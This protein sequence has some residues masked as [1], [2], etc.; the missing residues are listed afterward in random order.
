M[1]AQLED[2]T[3]VW[4]TPGDQR[5]T[6]PHLAIDVNGRPVRQ[7]MGFERD[8]EARAFQEALDDAKARLSGTGRASRPSPH[9]TDG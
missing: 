1:K 9:A 3:V 5:G 4:P 6:K 2:Y 8:D 7:S